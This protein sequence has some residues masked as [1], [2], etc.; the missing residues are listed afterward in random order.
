MDWTRAV[1][2]HMPGQTN[3]LLTQQLAFYLM[4]AA[5][6]PSSF[7]FSSRHAMR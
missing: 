6:S 3:T 1:C 7:L 4:T 2:P 5:V